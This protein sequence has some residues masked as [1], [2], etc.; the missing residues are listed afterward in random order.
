M[1]LV[2]QNLSQRCYTELKMPFCIGELKRSVWKDF[3]GIDT[4][5][6]PKKTLSP[7]IN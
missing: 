2:L 4:T 1:Q 7:I 5:E 3:L 6:E